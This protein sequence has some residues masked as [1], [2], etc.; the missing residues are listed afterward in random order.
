V[1]VTGDFG[2]PDRDSYHRETGFAIRPS[3]AVA[4]TYKVGLSYFH[5]DGKDTTRNVGG[6][7]GIL[8]F[9]K[10][11]FLLSEWDFQ[12]QGSKTGA[13]PSQTGGLDYNRLDYEFIQ[14]LHGYLTQ[15]FAEL[16]FNDFTTLHNS[17]GVGVQ[18]FPRP[19]F[20]INASYQRLRQ[21]FVGNAYTDF[22]WLMIN[23]YI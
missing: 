13:F 2:R 15:D 9:T 19:H 23:L 3:L 6:P 20:E 14:G 1:F 10:R 18:F 7:W 5:G 12:Q 11:F 4:D 22:A 16:N 8:G 21:I 17:F